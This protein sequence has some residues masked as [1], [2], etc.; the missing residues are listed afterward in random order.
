MTD[1]SN[2]KRIAKNTLL[3]YFR[4]IITML[5]SL[6]TSRVVLNILGVEE[7]GIYNVVGG[8]VTMLGFL[9]NS[10]AGATQRFLT[11]ELGK[12]NKEKFKRVFSTSVNIH[13]IISA[14]VVLLAETIGLWFLYNKMVIPIDK[15]NA[16]FWVYQFSILSCVVMFVSVPYNAAIIA[17]ERMGAFAYIS[18]IDVMLKLLI[19]F[20]LT[21]TGFDK[22]IVYSFLMF[23]IQLVIRLVY[24]IYCNKKI[25]G[26]SYHFIWNRQLFRDMSSFAGWQLF[27]N[28][29]AVAY[30][31][32]VNILLNIFFGPV[33]NAAR[34]VAVQVQNAIQSFSANF[35]QAMNPQITKTYANNELGRMHSLIF[36]SSKY[37][38]FLLFLLSLPVLIETEMILSLWLKNVPE[39]TLNFIRIILV[40][41]MVETL[42]NPLVTAA[43][44]TG[45][46][47]IYQIVVGGLLLLI[48][49]FSYLALK[50]G[51]SPEVVF[52][53]HLFMV[54]FAQI[55]RLYMI[56]PMVS[57]SLRRYFKEVVIRVIMV[58]ALSVVLPL[59]FFINLSN[60]ITSFVFVCV[61]SM[62]SVLLFVFLVGLR[63]AEKDVVVQKINFIYNKVFLIK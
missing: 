61:L 55:A 59:I 48:L 46:I 58:V 44:A 11:F 56:R 43:G 4:M 17:H 23:M 7:F 54:V 57:L 10:M 5:V 27:G 34:G 25:P 32:G 49:P 35:Q 28:I 33:V 37:S 1:F 9:N 39:H 38:F 24:G 22:L 18:L 29:A 21:L 45:K 36:A 19:V 15:L 8:V 12:G 51:G 53:V 26:T 50:V 30:S 16:A 31:Q 20:L 41:S 62:F 13:I 47:K 40:V 42:A 52:L 6:Y 3:L 63:Q 14:I 60:T 2:N